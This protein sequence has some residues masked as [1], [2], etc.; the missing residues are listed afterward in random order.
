MTAA[1]QVRGACV[2]KLGPSSS[3]LP[4]RW[5]RVSWRTLT[6]GAPPPRARPGAAA[7]GPAKPL[8]APGSVEEHRRVAR[9]LTALLRTLVVVDSAPEAAREA[10]ASGLSALARLERLADSIYAP[11]ALLADAY[12]AVVQALCLG[13]CAARKRRRARAAQ[14]RRE[15]TCGARRTRS[16]T[17]LAPPRRFCELP[18]SPQHGEP[19]CLGTALEQLQQVVRQRA[20]RS[21]TRFNDTTA[22]LEW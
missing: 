18:P 16:K 10:L 3:E 21:R 8:V 19:Q 12:S 7:G 22:R 15:C 9:Q 13:G 17:A 5:R 20:R 1:A 14:L 6:F 2:A 4:P 11:P